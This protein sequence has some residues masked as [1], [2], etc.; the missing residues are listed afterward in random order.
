MSKVDAQRALRDARYARFAAA[1]K[2]EAAPAKKVP[3][4]APAAKAATK[5]P[6]ATPAAEPVPDEL[7]SSLPVEGRATPASAAEPPSPD[8]DSATGAQV[9]DSGS[10]PT[11]VAGEPSAIDAESAPAAAPGAA[12]EVEAEAEEELCGHRSMNGRS[13]TRTKGHEQ[14]N[15]RYN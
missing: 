1:K 10:A 5:G 4:K 11:P 2:S 3:A 8:S 6:T 12:A 13:C 14:K 7:F 15:H 9:L